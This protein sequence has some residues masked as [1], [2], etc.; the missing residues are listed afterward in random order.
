[1]QCTLSAT[2]DG[3]TFLIRAESDAMLRTLSLPSDIP[4][5]LLPEDI[6]PAGVIDVVR[7]CAEFAVA[8]SL[9]TGATVIRDGSSRTTNRFLA[10]QAAHVPSIAKT[11]DVLTSYGRPIAQALSELAGSGTWV[12]ACHQENAMAKMPSVAIAKLHDASTHVFLVESMTASVL[13]TLKHWSCDL[14]FPGYPYPL[15]LADQLAR[16]TNQE[17]DAHRAILLADPALA[18]LLRAELRA[19]DA[20]DVFEHILYGKEMI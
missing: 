12:A 20:H 7:T 3:Q 17:R 4:A 1:M 9:S 6:T 11:S 2:R 5:A 10:M 19:S 8:K 15:V 16:V 18:K 14:A 13:S